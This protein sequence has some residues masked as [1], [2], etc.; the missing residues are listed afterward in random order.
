MRWCAGGGSRTGSGSARRCGGRRWNKCCSP[1]PSSRPVF[2]N[3]FKRSNSRWGY[4]TGNTVV[5]ELAGRIRSVAVEGAV[6][7]RV[8]GDEF[9]V[10]ADD[11]DPRGAME[12]AVRMRRA[13]AL[14]LPS[15]SGKGTAISLDATF[16]LYWATCGPSWQRA[17]PDS[18]QL[19]HDKKR[20]DSFPAGQ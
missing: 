2:V 11:V 15:E 16:V 1:K 20:S 4:A 17:L 3:A 8:G 12:L 6:A 10:L 18:A 9:I 5:A 13:C 14:S 7:A 19:L